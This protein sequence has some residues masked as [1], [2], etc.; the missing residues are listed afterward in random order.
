MSKI[1]RKPINI[2]NVQV[3]IKGQEVHYK[4]PKNAGVYALPES[5][6]AH[7][8]EGQLM[9]QPAHADSKPSRDVNKVWGLH[10]ALL[11]NTIGGA[12]VEFEKIVKI[13]GLGYKAAASGSNLVFSLGYSHKIDFELPKLV[14]VVIDKTGQILTIKSSNKELA[15]A[16]VSKIEALRPTEPYKGTG[17]KEASKTIFRK[18][19]KTKSS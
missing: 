11:A 1:G 12:S 4:G 15:G 3:T 8:S 14:S 16:V 10:R 6:K 5:L 18:A 2:N 13:N 19:G 9:L 7:V 17:I